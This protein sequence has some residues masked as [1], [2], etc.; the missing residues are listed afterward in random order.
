MLPVVLFAFTAGVLT[1]V[2][3]CTLPVLPAILGGG[4][5]P[6]RY[7]LLGL[8]VGFGGTFLA[9]TFLLAGALAALDIT[10]S[11]LRSIAALVLLASGAM[12]AGPAIARLVEGA[13]PRRA[14]APRALASAG[15]RGD[16]GFWRGIAMGG[17]LG[18]IWAPCVG[19]LMG[20]VIAAAVV[21]GPT[22]GGIA[23]GGA[24]VLGAIIPIGF[25]AALGRRAT[26]RVDMPTAARV[27]RA[28]GAGMVVVA[29]VVLTG[30]DASLAAD[31]TAAFPTQPGNLIEAAGA[32]ASPQPADT[33]ET[34]DRAALADLGPAPELTGIT[35]WIN[36][37]AVT[38]ASLRG[39]VVLVEFWTFGCVNCI[40]VAPYVRAWSDTYEARGLTVIG[41]H[42][43]ELSFERNLD[44]VRD[45]V[46]KADIRYRVA[47][48]PDF[49]T[50]R[51]YQNHYW[52]AIYLI[53]K[54]GHIRL[55]RS[56]EGGYDET[57]AAIRA[58]LAEPT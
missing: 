13:I 37:D 4:I 41:V 47:F 19:P 44:N 30:T 1:I 48:D 12:L 21:D 26:S 28:F 46:A 25:V 39:R 45:A 33:S 22:A 42:T 49:A 11:S 6:G 7:R 24:Y 3:P 14:T 43:P 17:A 54:R 53:D 2:A 27:R 52:P 18:L 35:A 10:S 58:L 23:V 36:G 55:V 50:W 9:L 38:L 5:G 57:D 15:G 16:A 34:I 31:L 40:H 32:G 20:P 29:I 56:G 8:C 51:A